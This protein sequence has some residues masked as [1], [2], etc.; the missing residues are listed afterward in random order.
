MRRWLTLIPFSLSVSWSLVAQPYPHDLAAEPHRY[1]ERTPKDAF[2]RVKDDLE[3][4]RIPLDR[5]SESAFLESLLRALEIPP[6]SQ[7]LV[8]ST[9]SLQIRLISPEAPR[10]LY[11][12]E[13]IYL[14]YVQRG[15]IEVIALDPELGSIF[16]IFDIPRE[17]EPLRIERSDRCMNCHAGTE[18][19]YVPGLLVKS[20]IPGPNRGSLVTFR[21]DSLGHG[22]PLQDRFG[23][24]YLTGE[25]GTTNHWA[26]VTGRL[27]QGELT[28]YPI[29]PGVTFDFAKYPAPT[30]DVFAH[31]VHEHQAG[32]VNLITDFT[33]RARFALH[34]GSGV[35]SE[36]AA[37]QL[38]D[39]AERL[40][41]YLLFADEVPLPAGGVKGDARFQA[42]FLRNRKPAGDGSSLKDF[43]LQTR[44]FRNRC[45]YMI[46]SPMIAAL[47]STIKER[48]YAKLDRALD[49]DQDTGLGSH[50]PPE[51]KRQIRRILQETLTDY[52]GGQL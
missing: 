25:L 45:S 12:N 42:D 47:P 37:R 33:Y 6:S 20:V 32:A 29:T 8:F 5:N 17:D 24:W 3:S 7:L 50:L 28:T 1:W 48:L 52:P 4:G 11:F 9:S 44:L 38:D 15:R 18:T 19:G 2:A 22:V 10:G 35:L 41:R 13:E 31:L 34:E 40:L 49:P 14:G 21:E 46:Y 23:G 26:N 36:E 51:E 16:Y 27:F 43:D 39:S 30:S